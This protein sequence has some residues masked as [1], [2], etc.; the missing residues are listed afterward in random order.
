MGVIIDTN[1][2]TKGFRPLSWG[3]SFNNMTGLPCSQSKWVCF[4]PLSWGLS[5]NTYYRTTVII[6]VDEVFVPFL[7]DFLSIQRRRDET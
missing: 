4:R 2:P 7:G 5:F 1:F 3:L 6:A